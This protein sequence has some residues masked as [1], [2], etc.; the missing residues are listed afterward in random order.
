MEVESN[1]YR[2]LRDRSRDEPDAERHAAFDRGRK[3]PRRDHRREADLD[4]GSSS[5]TSS[6]WLDGNH[7]ARGLGDI[8]MTTSTNEPTLADRAAGASTNDTLETVAGQAQA[9]VASGDKL[10]DKAEEKYLSAGLLLI[11]LKERLPVERPGVAWDLWA[12]ANLPNIKRSR[13]YALIRIAEGKTTVVAEREKNAQA[14]RDLRER[15]AAEAAPSPSRDGQAVVDPVPEAVEIAAGIEAGAEQWAMSLSNHASEAISMG[16]LWTRL[17]GDWRRF[18]VPSTAATLARQA[19]RAWGKLADELAPEPVIEVSQVQS[20]SLLDVF[21]DPA[22]PLHDKIVAA[23][24]FCLM[25]A[26]QKAALDAISLADPSVRAPDLEG[27]WANTPDHERAAFFDLLRIAPEHRPWHYQ[28]ASIAA[29]PIVEPP[30]FRMQRAIAALR[31]LIANF[32]D[33]VFDDDEKD[34]GAKMIENSLAAD[35]DWMSSRIERMIEVMIP[36]APANVEMKKAERWARRAAVDEVESVEVVAAVEKPKPNSREAVAARRAAN[37]AKQWASVAKMK[38]ER[39]AV[40][41]A[42]CHEIWREI[43]D[44]LVVEP[45]P[46]EATVAGCGAGGCEG[47]SRWETVDG[48]RHDLGPC[49]V[50]HPEAYA[51]EVIEVAE[52]TVIKPKGNKRSKHG[53]VTRPDPEAF[54][55]IAAEALAKAA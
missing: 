11:K 29:V 20:E 48:V 30:A 46:V 41:E 42:K 6:S 28:P 15:K 13:Q 47:G 32:Y 24:K 10:K 17:F 23:V 4:A 26:E 43:V 19:A 7:R 34:R 53:A 21:G 51:A 8:D 54:A 39:E 9:L 55:K 25:P 38:A 2:R 3:N 33:G 18:E 37:D 16:P 1:R 12:A 22:A 44:V 27:V 52:P 31:G 5:T 14:N 49:G 40:A 50:C 36:E 35:D 45:E